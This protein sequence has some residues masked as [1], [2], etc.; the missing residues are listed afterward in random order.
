[1]KRRDD[2]KA[3]DDKKSSRDDDANANADADQAA[4][5]D[6]DSEMQ[7]ETQEEKKDEEEAEEPSA[8]DLVELQIL[9]PLD[10][11]ARQ[12]AEARTS[13]RW[14]PARVL[15]GLDLQQHLLRPDVFADAQALVAATS[16]ATGLNKQSDD[17][18][19]VRFGSASVTPAGA[20]DEY[21]S[22][23]ESL[24]EL[25]RRSDLVELNVC[26]LH[27]CPV[28][29]SCTDSVRVMWCCIAGSST[30]R[31]PGALQRS[32]TRWPRSLTVGQEA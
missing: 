19:D 20:T 26:V 29:V 16:A 12:R 22:W 3:A 17:V 28:C 30:E 18:K 8:L 24:M 2:D 10:D 25:V 31:V 13:A 4:T 5:Q 27:V 6:A 1:M 32:V 15:R 7:T 14:S 21:C 9:G 11:R 23:E